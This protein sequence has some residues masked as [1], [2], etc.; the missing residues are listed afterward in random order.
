MLIA[1]FDAGPLV[2]ACKFETKGKLVIDHLLSGCRIVITPSVEEEV[3]IVGA[4]YPDG[5]VA[6]ERI[7]NGAVRVIPVAEQRWAQCLADYA[8]GDGERDSIEL[9]AQAEE[10]EALV[11]D[12][13]LAFVA[14]T[15]LALKVWMLPDLVLQLVERGNLTPEL[16]EVI[17]EAI[18]PR[19]RVGV[20]E[21]SLVCL[22]EVK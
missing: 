14:A 2:T 7:A 17:L 21:H 9:C 3:A 22:R 10:V 5:V 15:R 12:D 1:V 6:G 4:R 19:Y 8:L 16:A 18:R 13:Y 11:T 20:I